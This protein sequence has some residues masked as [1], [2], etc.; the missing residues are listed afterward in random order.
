MSSHLKIGFWMTA[1]W[2]HFWSLFSN[3]DMSTVT[4]FPNDDIFS[5]EDS[6]AFDF[7]E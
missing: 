7:F 4:A 2:A 3:D 5:D 6:S 1:N